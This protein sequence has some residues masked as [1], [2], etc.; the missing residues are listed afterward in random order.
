MFFVC[1]LSS[2]LG[3]QSMT[4]DSVLHSHLLLHQEREHPD[5]RKCSCNILYIFQSLNLINSIVI[6]MSVYPT[7][8][9]ALQVFF[10]SSISYPLCKH[11]VWGIVSL[12]QIFIKC[13]C[14][15]KEELMY[16]IW[17]CDWSFASFSGFLF[18]CMPENFKPDFMLWDN[19][20]LFPILKDFWL[21]LIFL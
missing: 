5:P 19:N 4:V 14:L 10:I 20:Y 13:I 17:L 11:G 2:S 21:L 8:W 12:P 15:L 3:I 18:L 7:G 9:W 1:V 6:I 16:F